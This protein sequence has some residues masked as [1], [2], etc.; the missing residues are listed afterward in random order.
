MKRIIVL[1]I[2]IILLL[3]FYDY[4]SKNMGE[5]KTVVDNETASSTKIT[6]I[7]DNYV[8]DERL[9]SAHGFSC[10]VEIDDKKILFDTG[11][12]SETLLSNME[13]LGIKPTQIDLV[14]LS[15]IHGDHTGGMHG[16]LEK[17]SKATMY[18]SSSFPDSF[19]EEIKSIGANFVDVS[20][21]IKIWDSVYSTGELGTWIKEQSLV[22]DAEKGLIVITG[23]A[24]PGIINIVRK[25]KEQFNKNVYLVLGGFHLS[26]ASDPELKS[27]IKEFRQLGVQ[28]V[29]PCHCSGDRARELFKTEYKDNFIDL[30]VGNIINI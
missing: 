26:E 30:G 15:H 17:N 5:E 29:A 22:I 9:K 14:V 25:V 1:L 11:G 18:I 24:H 21:S 28:K 8:I 19:R 3:F 2:A 4:S 27:I 7:Y 16:F 23:C 13:M 6:I 20:E 12:D 10:L